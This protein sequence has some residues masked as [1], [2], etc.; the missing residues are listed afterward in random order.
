MPLQRRLPKRGFRNI[1]GKSYATVN[2]EQLK[3]FEANSEIT[4]EILLERK[5]VRKLKDGVKVLAKGEIR[6]P[7]MLKVHAI[8]NAAREKI[9]K[10]GGRV[11]LIS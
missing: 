5:V 6:E 9:L 3:S 2:L 7:V 1:F 10:I 11:D 8:S 4:P